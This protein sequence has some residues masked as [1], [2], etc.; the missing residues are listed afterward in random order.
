MKKTVWFW[1]PR[2]LGLLFGAF[3]ALFALDVFSMEDEPLRLLLGFLVHTIPTWIILLATIIAWKWER[4]GGFLFFFIA[5]VALFFFRGEWGVS[6]TICTILAV[7][8]ALFLWDAHR[9]QQPAE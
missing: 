7:I 5:V 6:I 9:Q 3:L 2:I 1:L 4:L 8:G